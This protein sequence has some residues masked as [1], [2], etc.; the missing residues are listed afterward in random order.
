VTLHAMNSQK[1]RQGSFRVLRPKT[2]SH[3]TGL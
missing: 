1:V 3:E 2:V